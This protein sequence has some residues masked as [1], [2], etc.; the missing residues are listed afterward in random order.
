M[1]R[2]AKTRG[3][4]VTCETAPHY[5]SLDDSAVRTGNTNAKVN[6]PLRAKEDVRAVRQGIADGTI[7]AIATDHAPHTQEDKAGGFAGAAFGLI[8]FETAYSLGMMYL[9]HSGLISEGRLEELMSLAPRKILSLGGGLRIGEAADITICDPEEEY[10]YGPDSVVSKSRNSPF[11]GGRMRGS[12]IYTIVDG[13]IV[14][15]RRSDR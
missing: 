4:P 2:N 6:P 3:V 13:G 7:D 15:D 14:Y 1:V 12:V 9:V 5:F 8:G 11:L 10:I